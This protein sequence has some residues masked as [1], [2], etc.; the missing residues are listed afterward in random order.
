MRKILLS[1]ILLCGFSQIVLSSEF[2]KD[3]KEKMG[4]MLISVADKGNFQSLRTL[5]DLGVGTSTLV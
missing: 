5:V 2:S 4:D 1:F 3:S